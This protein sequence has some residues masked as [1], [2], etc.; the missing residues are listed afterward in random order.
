MWR[1]LPKRIPSRQA[2][3]RPWRAEALEVRAAHQPQPITLWD[4]DREP[5]DQV[6]H[7]PIL[8]KKKK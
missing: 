1:S 3:R 8:L 4:E 5:R 6:Q 2:S 7:A